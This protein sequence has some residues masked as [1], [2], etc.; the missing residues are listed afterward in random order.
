V[1]P[2][3]QL[4]V[5]SPI[6]VSAIVGAVGPAIAGT[7][8]PVL[9]VSSALRERYGAGAV[10]LTD[11]G[12]SALVIALRLAAGRG[13]TVAYPAYGCV[14]LAAAAERAGVKV[15]LYDVD[16]RTLSADL[17]S[18][19]S[20]LRRGVDAVVAVHLFG[21]PADVPAM[22]SLASEFG[23]NVIED[24]A[25]GA[26]GALRGVS[27]GGL[28]PLSVLSFG[29]GKGTSGGNGGALL[30]VDA[31]WHRALTDAAAVL[32]R[33]GA[34]WGDLTVAAAQ[35]MLGRPSIYGVPAAI[36][37]LRLGEMVYRAAGEPRSLSTAAAALV[38]R[39]LRVATEEVKVR[40]RNAERLLGLA[41]EADRISIVRAVHGAEPGYLRFPVVDSAARGAA[42]RLGVLRP[43]PGTLCDQGA[44]VPLLQ[45]GEAAGPGATQLGRQLFTLPTHS[46]VA[47][48]DLER[49]A[50]WLRN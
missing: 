6:E 1:I 29:R 27:L 28:G 40:R 8:A 30:A 38:R 9:A 20:A 36:P 25:Q 34:G 4:P 47:A 43:Y 26:S 2:R 19:R 21:Y 12:T 23:A 41:R 15:R 45:P 32:G 14:D 18:L 17:D 37:S 16:P 24:A 22:V 7:A 33:P 13:G 31:K 3:H 44:L 46:R 11:S 10:A 50:H 48:S 39:A 42:P 35:W 5:L 49:L